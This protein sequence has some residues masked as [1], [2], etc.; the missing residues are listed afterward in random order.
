MLALPGAYSRRFI[1]PFVRPSVRP[2]EAIS[3][4]SPNQFGFNF[5]Y[6]LLKLLRRCTFP[7]FSNRRSVIEKGGFLKNS[8][9]YEHLIQLL[10]NFHETSWLGHILFI[11]SFT[12]CPCFILNPSL[13]ISF[14][15]N[16]MK[17]HGNH[18]Y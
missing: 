4:Q 3:P 13:L 8:N 9:F 10:S 5:M 1:C 2:S 14:C 7:G 15:K 6:E 17:L 11:K 16:F 18:V 12:L